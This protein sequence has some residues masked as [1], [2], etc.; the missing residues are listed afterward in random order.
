MCC[1][2]ICSLPLYL[3]A[4]SWRLFCNETTSKPPCGTSTSARVFFPH[5]FRI[6]AMVEVPLLFIST[7]LFFS[8]LVFFA[9]PR[10]SPLALMLRFRSWRS[11]SFLH[12]STS[13]L[14]HL[15]DCPHQTPSS[16]LLWF[17]AGVIPP[18]IIP[19]FHHEETISH[20]WGAVNGGVV[21]SLQDL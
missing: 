8:G 10:Q 12:T 13:L 5:M 17:C 4:R 21:E 19:F 15:M 6:S 2:C 18:S 7:S 9:F 11:T 20:R 14:R 3:M 1:W 16:A